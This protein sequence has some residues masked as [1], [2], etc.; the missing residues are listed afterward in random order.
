MIQIKPLDFFRPGT[1]MLLHPYSAND[2]LAAQAHID[3]FL[4]ESEEK[5]AVYAADELLCYAGIIR[6][7]LANPPFIWMLLGKHLTALRSRSF[8][9]ATQMLRDRYPTARLGVET[10][11]TKGARFAKF[12]GLRAT[13]QLFSVGVQTFEFYEVT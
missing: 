2:F 13:G 7:V 3:T 6:P 11:F 10:N 8:R 9:Q 1:E 12:C 5:W 4:K